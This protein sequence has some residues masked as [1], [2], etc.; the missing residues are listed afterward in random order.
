MNFKLLKKLHSQIFGDIYDWA[1]KVRNM[2]I[3]KSN[4]FCD[5]RFIEQMVDA[6]FKELEDENYLQLYDVE[7]Q[8][9]DWHIIY[10]K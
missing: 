4:M 8:Q 1:G 5:C 9:T 6:I 2:N 3:T 7:K 10:Q